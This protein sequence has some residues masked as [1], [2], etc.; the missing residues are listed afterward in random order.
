MQGIQTSYSTSNAVR[1]CVCCF[2][3]RPG[4]RWWGGCSTRCPW[5]WPHPCQLPRRTKKEKKKWDPYFHH[6]YI[7]HTIDLSITEGLKKTSIRRQEHRFEKSYSHSVIEIGFQTEISHLCHWLL[8]HEKNILSFH[9]SPYPVRICVH[10][11]IYVYRFIWIC[12]LTRLDPGP[13]EGET[14]RGHPQT[15]QQT[16]VGLD[17]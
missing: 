17:K 11:D 10:M 5:D 1:W 9:V 13:G 12:V 16:D 3:L 7:M 6:V 2:H 15:L 14:V 8:R 4:G